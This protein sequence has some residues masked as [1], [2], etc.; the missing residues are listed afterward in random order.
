M[1]L[2]FRWM[3]SAAGLEQAGSQKAQGSPGPEWL[4]QRLFHSVPSAHQR[5]VGETTQT[6]QG[7]FFRSLCLQPES[8]SNLSIGF[9][10]S[11]RGR[12]N[13]NETP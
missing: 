12:S 11:K 8:C 3:V 7:I 10:R 1:V 2:L 6:F 5:E 4:I 13:K 9:L